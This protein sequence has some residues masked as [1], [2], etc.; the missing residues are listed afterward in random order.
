VKPQLVLAALLV[1]VAVPTTAT[2]GSR[3]GGSLA[4]GERLLAL[5]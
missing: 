5:P 4:G 2:A 3:G 1:L